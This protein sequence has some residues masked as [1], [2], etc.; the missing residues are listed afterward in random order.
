M[1]LGVKDNGEIN[2]SF[3][4]RAHERMDADGQAILDYIEIMVTVNLQINHLQKILK[5][6]FGMSKGSFKRAVGRLFKKQNNN[7][8]RR[9]II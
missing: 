6:V 8:R 4:P 2:G 7:D 9:W 3:L 1:L 5:A